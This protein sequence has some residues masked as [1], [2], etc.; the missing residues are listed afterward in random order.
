MKARKNR[1]LEIALVVFLSGSS[2][3]DAQD[4]DSPQ[5]GADETLMVVVRDET[6]L[7]TNVFFP[8]QGGEGPWPVI[9][10]RSPYGKD[11]LIGHCRDMA[12]K[13]YAVVCQD[14]RGRGGSSGSDALVFRS[15]GDDGRDTLA[16]IAKQTW[17]NGNICTTGSSALGYTQMAAAPGAPPE[18]KAMHVGVTWSNMYTQFVH[19]GGTFRTIADRWLGGSGPGIQDPAAR[20]E[21]TG[22]SSYDEFWEALDTDSQAIRMNAP[23]VYLGGWYDVFAQGTI[24]AFVANHNFGGPGA[25]RQC[26]LIM[27]PYSHGIVFTAD[28]KI[29]YPNTMVGSWDIAH[30]GNRIEWFDYWTKGIDNGVGAE[31]AVIYYVMGDIKD[32][33]APGNH[34]RWADNWPPS[35]TASRFYLHSDGSLR[36]DQSAEDTDSKSYK[37]D[38]KSPV[39]TLG[40]Q[41]YFL[42]SG[43]V[44]LRKVEE[45]PDVLLFTSP[46]LKQPLDVTGRIYARLYVSSDCPDTDF[47]V[48]LSDVYPDGTSLLVTDGVLR[49]RFH[50]GFNRE[51]FLKPGVVYA[52]TVDLWNTALVFNKGHRVRVAVSSSN[53]PRFDPNPN[54]GKK[55]GEEDDETRVATN[56]IHLSKA[57]P[58]H[59]TLPVYVGP[60]NLWKLLKEP[61][62][63]KKKQE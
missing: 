20:R 45:R 2:H 41:N 32:E 34:W 28:P 12:A 24:N 56:T 53:T 8:P 14:T 62:T 38:P 25:R 29:V 58:S 23:T 50:T 48:T 60:Q 40:G 44:D 49:A 43:P 33:D 18:L 52:L 31:P 5:G 35:A 21:W 63:P 27:G 26:R 16:W 13:G 17:C 39:P 55:L 10:L 7:A 51:V 57:H 4:L 42:P 37:Y 61:S 47:T 54:T 30:A 59:I 36:R 46:V 22:H 3:L 15:D 11:N 9:L 6:K 1:I 19:Q